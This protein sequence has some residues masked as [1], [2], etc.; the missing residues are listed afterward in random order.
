MA[1]THPSCLSSVC[2]SLC[3]YL[4]SLRREKGEY[5]H[6]H[7]VIPKDTPISLVIPRDAHIS[8]VLSKDAHIS[9]VLPKDAHISLVLPKDAHIRKLG[10]LLPPSGNDDAPLG[11]LSASGTRDEKGEAA[12]GG[13]NEE[14]GRRRLQ[15]DGRRRNARMVAAANER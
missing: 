7:L 2:P 6:T 12:G 11:V 3:P 1:F 8:L 10:V 13:R 15:M 9:L 4:K 14:R 5:K